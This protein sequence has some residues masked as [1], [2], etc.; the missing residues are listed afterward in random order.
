M[1]D[2][3]IWVPAEHRALIAQLARGAV[4]REAPEELV[5][6]EDSATQFFS[7][8]NAVMQGDRRDESVGFGLDL[9]MLTP[10]ALAV[11]SA[12]VAAVGGAVGD[13]WK[14]EA[15]PVVSGWFRRLF[16]WLSRRRRRNRDRRDRPAAPR[17]VPLTV[18]QA[19]R[20]RAVAVKRAVAFGV[21]ADQARLL[22]ESITGALVTGE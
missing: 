17:A 7:N 8:A 11:A 9:A 4:E 22:A 1:P 3:E 10:A 5:L 13:A 21:P 14:D 19:R 16:H 2:D 20:V 6:F 15:T 12:V 18:E